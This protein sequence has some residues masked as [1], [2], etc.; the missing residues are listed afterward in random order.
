[1]RHFAIAK[2]SESLWNLG[3]LTLSQLGRSVFDEILAN[4]VLGHAAELAFYFLFALFPL[5]LIVI[6]SFGLFAADRIELQKNLL[7]YFADLLPPIAFNLLQTVVN[8]VA[9]HASSGKLTFGIVAGL[10]AVAGGIDSMIRSLNL[11]HH[12]RETR[13]QLKLRAITIGLSLLISVLVLCALFMVLIGNRVVNWLG[14]ALGLHP[15]IVFVWKAIQWPGFVFVVLISCALIYRF[16]PN[17]EQRRRWHWVSPGGA[18]GVFLWLSVSYGFRMYL[19]FFNHFSATYGS[20]GAVMIL[21]L[22]LYVFALAYL[23]GGEIN[24]VIER[25]GV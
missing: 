24:A 23:T 16:G 15:T 21:M 18:F 25:T 13:S 5:I 22:W 12:V 2:Q 17:L 11:A 20:L 14:A 3:G 6:T 1:M 10:L 9:A 4:N 19:H 8:E 7:S